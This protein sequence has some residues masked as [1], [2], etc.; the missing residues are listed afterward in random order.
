MRSFYLSRFLK[1]MFLI[2]IITLASGASF[3]KESILDSSILP[4]YYFCDLDYDTQNISDLLSDDPKYDVIKNTKTV[5]IIEE[6]WMTITD[7]DYWNNWRDKKKRKNNL[8]KSAILVS[9]Y[10]LD[11][12]E[13]ACK[14]AELKI[15]TGLII[16]PAKGVKSYE[17]WTEG[18][19]S[20]SKI[21]DNCWSDKNSAYRKIARNGNGLTICFIKG[22]VF[23]EVSGI[24]PDDNPM[25]PRF[26]EKIAQAIEKRL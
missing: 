10:Y 21:G 8:K 19:Y 3:K 15:K 25:D 24:G 13:D 9:R 22:N 6:N 4:G 16:L 12:K 23:I 5:K 7:N 1:I 14:W 26:V 17:Q 18:G 11:S 2:I 20:I